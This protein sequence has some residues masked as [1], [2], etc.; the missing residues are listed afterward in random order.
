M[1]LKRVLTTVLGL[2]I[3]ALV[4]LYGNQYVI[5]SV[6]LVVSIICMYEYYA[7]I[8]KVVK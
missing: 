6:I 1:D 7:A 3:V 8:K 4:F 5:G 2:P